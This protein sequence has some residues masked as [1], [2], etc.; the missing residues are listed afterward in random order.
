MQ[1]VATIVIWQNNIIMHKLLLLV[2]EV[3]YMQCKEG[4][5]KLGGGGGGE[6]CFLKLPLK[7]LF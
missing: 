7:I 2:N 3:A 4:S 1:S 5:D 6:K